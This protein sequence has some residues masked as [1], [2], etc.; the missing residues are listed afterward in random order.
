VENQKAG[1]IAQAQK[2]STRL[3]IYR[4]S[5]SAGHAL[6]ALPSPTD[7]ERGREYFQLSSVEQKAQELGFS[8]SRYKEEM[9]GKTHSTFS[10]WIIVKPN[11]KQA[12]RPA[13]L[14][15]VLNLLS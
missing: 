3:S 7:D 4:A 1:T 11:D 13:N 8:Y 15:Y 6:V 9:F 5:E 14:R 2:R 10:P 12:V